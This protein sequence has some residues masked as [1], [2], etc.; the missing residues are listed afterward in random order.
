MKNV[1][2][3]EEQLAKFGE[4][5]MRQ[6]DA[7]EKTKG[8]LKK[9][10]V[11]D[12]QCLVLTLDGAMVDWEVLADKLKEMETEE[13]DAQK[14]VDRLKESKLVIALGVRDN[15][16]LAL[17]RFVVGGSGK[18]GQGRTADRPRRSSSR[19]PNSPTSG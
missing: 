15:Y 19:W 2:L 1:K 12:H 8:R 14:I 17:H 9:T 6:L 4:I 11:G 18:A 5:A 16:L 10:K 7:N 3:A 13:G